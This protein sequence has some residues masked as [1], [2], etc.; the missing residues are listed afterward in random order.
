MICRCR[1]HAYPTTCTISGA[2]LGTIVA[3]VQAQNCCMHSLPAMF[4]RLARCAEG[5]R[6]RVYLIENGQELC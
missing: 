5:G 3:M 4:K 2:R 1:V 6:M